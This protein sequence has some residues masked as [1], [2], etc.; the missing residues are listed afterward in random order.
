MERGVRISSTYSA[1]LVYGFPFT[2]YSDGDGF[3]E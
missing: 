2:L 1:I 3:D